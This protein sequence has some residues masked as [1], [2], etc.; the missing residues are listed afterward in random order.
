M[1]FDLLQQE[2]IKHL[3]QRRLDWALEEARPSENIEEEDSSSI[4]LAMKRAVHEAL[5]WLSD[6]TNVD[7]ERYKAKQR[8]A[9]QAIKKQKIKTWEKKCQEVESLKEGACSTEVWRT[10]EQMKTN[11]T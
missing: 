4:K 2:I 11:Q 3:Y 8:E 7:W 6:K 9:R 10:I 5:G 1:K